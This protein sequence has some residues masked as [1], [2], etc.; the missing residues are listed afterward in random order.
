MVVRMNIEVID[1]CKSFN[2][3]KLDNINIKVPKGKIIGLI[4]ENGAGKTTL[5]KC[6]LDIVQLDKGIVKLFNHEYSDTLKEDIGVVFDDSFMNETFNVMD[7]NL[8]MKNIYNNWDSNMYFNYLKKFNIPLKKKLRKLS[9]GM[10]KKIEIITAISHKPK[11]L[12]LDEPTSGLDP[13]IRSDILDMLENFVKDGSSSVLLSTHITSDLE[14]IADDVIL[15]SNGRV[16]FDKT[17][18]KIRNEYILLDLDYKEFS[19]FNKSIIIRY[20]KN[21]IDYQILI[22]KE[23]MKKEYNKYI[24]N[25]TTLE[26]IMLLYIKGEEVCPGLS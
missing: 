22:R 26:S 21:R 23:D 1:L 25:I 6:I 13:V 24:K 14:H 15:L 11:L 19:L 17:L 8:I 18:K 20:K 5:L 9:T 12:I 2:D 4:G 3:F 7:I 16:I 10:K